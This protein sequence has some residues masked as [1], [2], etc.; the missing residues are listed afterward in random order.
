M[1]SRGLRMCALMSC[2]NFF[3]CSLVLPPKVGGRYGGRYGRRVACGVSG[4]SSDEES[5]EVRSM[6]I[7]LPLLIVG[8]CGKDLEFLRIMCVFGKDLGFE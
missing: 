1:F 3:A 5:E 8:E 6:M 2:L 4:N 7:S